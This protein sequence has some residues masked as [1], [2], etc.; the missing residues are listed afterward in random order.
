MDGKEAFR[1]PSKIDSPTCPWLMFVTLITPTLI[2]PMREGERE[3]EM[4]TCLDL[5]A[6]SHQDRTGGLLLLLLLQFLKC[7]TL[8]WGRYRK[9]TLTD[10]S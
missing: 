3:E 2:S 8:C 10:V 9:E 1:E 5:M 6:S 7:C 4:I